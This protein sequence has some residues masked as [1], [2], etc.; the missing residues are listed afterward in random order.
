MSEDSLSTYG[1]L[2]EE[3]G[4]MPKGFRSGVASLSFIPAERPTQEPYKM[5]ISAL[6]TDKPVSSVAGVFTQNAFPGAPVIIARQRIPGKQ[7]QGFFVN[8]RIS[9][10]SSPTG[11]EDALTLSGSMAHHLGTQ[12]DV[13]LPVSTGIIG[14]RLPVTEMLQAQHQLMENLQDQSL[15]SFS[16]AIMTT[17]SFPK[18]RRAPLGSGSLVG[19]AKGAGMIEPNLATMLVFLVT[20]VKFDPDKAQQIL[21]QVAERTFNS[22]S[23]DSDQS[24][25]DM[26]TLLGS[27]VYDQVDQQALEHALFQVCSQLAED[28]VRNGEGT[29]HV[30]QMTVLGRSSHLEA[31][32]IARLL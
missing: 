25:S 22:I 3:R 17:D 14:W 13:I 21:G 30:I 23:V 9:N 4:V 15:V 5:N 31:R 27:E 2:L 16:R 11:I 29:S 10:V 24:T 28:I 8:N 18:I 19:V 7:I 6:V 12:G 20:D 32:S 1:K 26:V